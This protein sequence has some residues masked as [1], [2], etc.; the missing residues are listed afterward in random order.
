MSL[1]KYTAASLLYISTLFISH[2]IYVF[3]TEIAFVRQT[4]FCVPCQKQEHLLRFST[5]S[6]TKNDSQ[7]DDKIEYHPFPNQPYSRR[8]WFSNAVTS[9]GITLSLSSLDSKPVLASLSTI[10]SLCDPS[11]SVLKNYSN[12]R[13]IYILGSAHISSNSAE[14]AGRLVREIKPDA[15]FVEL[16]AKRVARTVSPS[17]RESSAIPPTRDDRTSPRAASIIK[18]T[19][20]SPSTTSPSL[21]LES[22]SPA[23]SSKNG[24]FNIRERA[25]E[26][27]SQMLG[28]AIKVSLPII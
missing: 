23:T 25:I 2:I 13:L 16:D 4:H 21:T 12:N 3:G 17:N 6:L 28:D 18:S 8:M 10:S 24:I 7:S 15:V 11:V 5:R 27:S 20:D 19:S 9:A 14:V 22:A 26:A 1:Y